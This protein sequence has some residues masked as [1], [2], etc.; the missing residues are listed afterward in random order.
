MTLLASLSVGL[1]LP[2]ATAGEN[3]PLDPD[4]V[5]IFS[6][7]HLSDADSSQQVRRFKM[8]V[9]KV[10]AM[11]PRPANLLIYG[12]VALDRGNV[13]DYLKFKSLIQPIEKAGIHWEV[14][15]GNHDRLQNYR[16][17]FPERFQEKPLVEDRCVHIVETPKAD[18]ILLD[19]YLKNEVR[20][21]IDPTQRAWLDETVKKRSDK[22][23][24]VGCHH[25]LRETKIENVLKQSPSFAAYLHGHNH[26][27]TNAAKQDVPTICFPSTGHWGDMGFVMVH[28]TENDA[29]FVPD[30]DEFLFSI[31]SGK[32][33]PL[34]PVEKYLKILNETTV[35]IPFKKKA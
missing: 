23:F 11:N 8:C 9:E 20:G 24:F 21:E 30:I 13:E 14:T 3:V 18:F 6:D 16:Q 17:V 22:P 25:P 26:C 31:W 29:A 5:A 2:S 27:W 35:T 4:L 1:N 32:A 12:D 15:M 33:A 34:I 28:L 19:S 7:A 10:L